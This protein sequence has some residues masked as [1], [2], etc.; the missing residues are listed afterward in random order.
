MKINEAFAKI[1]GQ[2]NACARLSSSLESVDNGGIMENLFLKGEAGLGKSAIMRAHA[3]ALKD[4]GFD[5][6]Y[7]E[8]SDEL[9]KNGEA[10]ATW[11]QLV[12]DSPRY[13]IF[14]DE[15]HKLFQKTTVQTDKVVAYLM[16]IGDGGNRNKTIRIADETTCVFNP[17]NHVVVMGTNLAG[18]LPDAMQN[19]FPGIRLRHYVQDE[20]VTILQSM[21]ER[22]EMKPACDKTLIDIA[23]CGRGTAR[24]MEK[25]IQQ[26]KVA[27]GHQKSSIN[28][29]D[30]K[31]A[32]KLAEM[33][34]WGVQ[35]PELQIMQ[36]CRAVP[37]RDIVLEAT[38]PSVDKKTLKDSKGFLCSKGMGVQGT[39]G[40]HTTEKGIRYMGEIEKQGFKLPALIG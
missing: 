23:K 35:V 14:F 4:R 27:V 31:N 5:V 3:E 28:K 19:R 33:F 11:L 37:H 25:I 16:K 36:V 21:L 40:F 20:L 10:F 26:L 17:S 34:P 24:P 12:M 8:H 32:L 13:A 38:L 9:R 7:L 6:M 29:E 22:E 18:K 2:E 1:V 15:V 39:N 30:V